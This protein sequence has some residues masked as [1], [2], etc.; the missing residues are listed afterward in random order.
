MAGPINLAGGLVSAA[1]VH[2]IAVV[3]FTE[4]AWLVVVFPSGWLTL[5]RLNQRYRAEAHSLDIVT[6]IRPD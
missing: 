3:K 4:G 5:M 2:L 6:G 1:V